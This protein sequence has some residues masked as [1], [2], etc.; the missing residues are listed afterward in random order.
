MNIDLH[1]EHAIAIHNIFTNGIHNLI[2]PVIENRA[3]ASFGNIEHQL[4]CISI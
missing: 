3:Q 2:I 4:N 1:M